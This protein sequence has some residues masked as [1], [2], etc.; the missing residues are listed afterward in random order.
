MEPAPATVQAWA[1]LLDPAA[2]QSAIQHISSL[3]LTRHICRPLDFRHKRI[4][5]S[6]LAKFDAA[7]EA[8][9]EEEEINDMPEEAL[10]SESMLSF[11]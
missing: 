11:A 3:N 1:L 8:A 5:N 4:D 7:V 6:E 9:V 10:V 2:A